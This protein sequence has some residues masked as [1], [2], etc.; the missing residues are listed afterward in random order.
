[1]SVQ[2]DGR[3]LVAGTLRSDAD[4]RVGIARYLMDDARRDQDADGIR[5]KPDRCPTGFS[6]RRR[7]CPRLKDDGRVSIGAD[8]FGDDRVVGGSLSSNYVECMDRRRVLILKPRPGK[9]RVVKSV[10][11]SEADLEVDQADL[12]R[13]SLKPGRYYAGVPRSV[14][15]VGICRALR[16]EVVRV[17]K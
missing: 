4:V 7:G 3:V 6:K 17:R 9:D 15:T 12:G 2:G 16:S 10:R 8:G 1:V 14:E 11:S 13:F 5:D